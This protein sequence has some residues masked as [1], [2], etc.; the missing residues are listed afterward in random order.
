MFSKSGVERLATVDK[1][2]VEL[3]FFALGS[4]ENYVEIVNEMDHDLI[5]LFR[6]MYMLF[7]AIVFIAF[8]NWLI[9]LMISSYDRMRDKAEA[10]SEKWRARQIMIYEGLLPLQKRRGQGFVNIDKDEHEKSRHHHRGGLFGK[11]S[12]LQIEVERL[13][14]GLE[15][16]VDTLYREVDELMKLA[17]IYK[18]RNRGVAQQWRADGHLSALQGFTRT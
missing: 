11:A 15:E 7:T 16:R 18:D 3:Y 9:A 14:H 4:M 8:G 6:I 2:F 12:P 5:G 17:G 1:V 10:I 13:H